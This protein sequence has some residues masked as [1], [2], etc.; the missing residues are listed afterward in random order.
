MREV[1]LALQLSEGKSALR[2]KCLAADL[3]AEA[4]FASNRKHKPDMAPLNAQRLLVVHTALFDLQPSSTWCHQSSIHIVLVRHF[5]SRSSLHLTRYAR[6]NTNVRLAV[7]CPS[8]CASLL[9]GR[10]EE[11]T[12]WTVVVDILD[13]LGGNANTL[14]CSAVYV[15]LRH[16]PP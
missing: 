4:D 9:A 12:K 15:S 6:S 1:V 7:N 14:D 16:R 8:T 5:D 2:L 13:Y 11:P 3:E 10:F